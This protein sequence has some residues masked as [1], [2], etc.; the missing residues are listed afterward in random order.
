MAFA[1]GLPLG[2]SLLNASE[3][4]ASAVPPLPEIDVAIYQRALVDRA[5]RLDAEVQR[6]RADLRRAEE[7]LVLA[8]SGLRGSHGRADA[9][10]TLAEVRIQVER[11]AG[12]ASWQADEI[13]EAR[14]KLEEA[15]RQIAAGNFGV[16]MFFAYRTARIAEHLEA[17][18]RAV[19]GRPGTLYV[20]V[21]GVNL[22]AG[23]STD[24]Q[25]IRVLVRGT[26]VFPEQTRDAWTLVRV[27]SGSVGWVHGNLL[28]PE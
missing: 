16:A 17:E 2:C 9:V 22:R 8:E 28:T 7:A 24:D 18:A 10:S 4:P 5:N 19:R 15:D 11:A 25:V 27:A 23:P 1:A 13:A 14:N 12:M 20:R 6:L 3:P 21:A 26:P